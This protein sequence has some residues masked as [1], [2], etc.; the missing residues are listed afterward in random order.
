ME[1][2]TGILN[3]IVEPNLFD[4][5][6]TELVNVPVLLV[7]GRLQ[8]LDGVGSVKAQRVVLLRPYS[9]ATPSLEFHFFFSS[10]KRHTRFSRDWSSDVCSSDL[11]AKTRP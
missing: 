1:D 5:C 2:E 4:A 6:W 8:N 11:P 10:G 7:E 3:I 9:A